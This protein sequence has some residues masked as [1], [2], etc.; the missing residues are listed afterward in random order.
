M[1]SVILPENSEVKEASVLIIEDDLGIRDGIELLLS[2]S[3]IGYDIH[4]VTAENGA[5]A[6]SYLDLIT[7]D[8]IISDVMMPKMGGFE[9]IRALR[10]Q[11]NLA[12]IPVIFLTARDSAE[13][14][15]EGLAHGVE[16]YLTKPFNSQELLDL[17][18]T[19]LQK[20]QQ[21]QDIRSMR[22][23][24]MRESISRT[25]QHELRTPMT[26][27]AGHLELLGMGL[28]ADNL[29]E[30]EA[31]ETQE[32]LGG[33]NLGI[34][35]LLHLINDMIA[36]LDLRSGRTLARIRAESAEIVD[37]AKLIS[38]AIDDIHKTEGYSGIFIENQVQ[39][40]DA[41]VY[42]HAALLKDSIGRLLG[43]AL[44]FTK[45]N[46]GGRI[47]I[48]ATIGNP[49]PSQNSAEIATTSNQPSQN[50]LQIH[51]ADNGIGFPNHIRHHLPDLFYQHDR[52]HWEQQGAGV[53]LTIV[54]G[55]V[56][57]HNGRLMIRS[58][59]KKGTRASLILPLYEAN[60]QPPELGTAPIM[61]RM[62]TLLLVDDDARIREAVIDTLSNFETHFNYE[63]FTAANGQQALDILAER[64]PDL[65]LSDVQMPV[66]DGFEMVKTIKQ[67]SDWVEIP[68]IFLTGNQRPDQRHNGRLL[69]VDEYIAKPYSHK[70]L[71]DRINT[72][73]GRQFE[74][75]SAESMTFDTF[76]DH[77]LAAIHLTVGDALEVMMQQSQE[78]RSMVLGDVSAENSNSADDLRLALVGI[79]QSS[80]QLSEK[81]Q[82]ATMLIEIRSGAIKQTFD[83]RASVIENIADLFFSI[84]RDCQAMASYD[85]QL[86]ILNNKE[87]TIE[88]PDEI[89]PIY[90]SSKLLPIAFT[91]WLVLLAQQTQADGRIHLSIERQGN[92]A[93]LT[94]LV[95]SMAQSTESKNIAGYTILNEYL[96]LHSA[97]IST[98]LDDEKYQMQITMPLFDI[99]SLT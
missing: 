6:L 18:R 91:K 76:K 41:Q 12:H 42:G 60:E 86:A 73:L 63:I 17:V 77:V 57:A 3:D 85:P 38:A 50:T 36:V 84:V 30:A 95:E 28:S 9:F 67:N 8:L 24:E 13:N 20:T 49:K 93:V 4:T 58:V 1:S 2:I 54:K 46:G 69:G 15:E 48:S 31:Q 81:V 10:E 7:P 96:A 19:Q 70:F 32:F 97:E 33:I 90:G 65:I 53:G 52:E 25:L 56:E 66:M 62:V 99:D 5:A 88:R 55:V 82:N 45:M 59:P 37:P 78:L 43:N 14:I 27:V 64:T 79:K 89:M 61:N 29:S 87:I 21:L 94:G 80:T 11:P 40:L 39:T 44:K 68:I 83:H 34:Q 47:V 23:Q 92:T 16:L 75:Q 22:E 98:D 74:K 72:I 26:L 51:I 71:I 35:R